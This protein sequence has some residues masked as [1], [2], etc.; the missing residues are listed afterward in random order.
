MNLNPKLQSNIYFWL[1]W[2]GLFKYAIYLIR[3][4]GNSEMHE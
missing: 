3:R 1:L 2:V 4:R